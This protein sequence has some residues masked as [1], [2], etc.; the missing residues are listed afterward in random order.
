VSENRSRANRSEGW[1]QQVSLPAV[2]SL[3]LGTMGISTAYGM[4]L[5]LPLYVRELGGDEASFGVIL[6]SAMV[7]AVLCIGLLI[8]Y[9]EAMRPHAVV[10]L[11][12]A[13][14]TARM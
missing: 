12:I 6:S 7:T 4:I 10:A 3:L 9:P 5:L 14:Y 1:Q 11:A 13:V 2:V 8:R